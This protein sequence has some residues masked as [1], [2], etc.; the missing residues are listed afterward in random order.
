MLLTYCKIFDILNTV[1]RNI[2]HER[3][4]IVEQNQAKTRG[5]KN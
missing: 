1:I 4:I 5:Y 3:R 2:E